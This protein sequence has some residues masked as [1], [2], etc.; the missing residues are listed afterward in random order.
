VPDVLY[1]PQ[2]GELPKQHAVQELIN[3]SIIRID[4]KC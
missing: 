4:S 3:A 2:V 1:R